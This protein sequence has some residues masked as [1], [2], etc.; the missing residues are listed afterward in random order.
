MIAMALCATQMTS[1]SS[2]SDDDGPVGGDT[3][4]FSYTYDEGLYVTTSGG[5]TAIS[6]VVV[7]YYKGDNVLV[8]DGF[9]FAPAMGAILGVMSISDVTATEDANGLITFTIANGAEIDTNYGTVDALYGE[10]IDGEINLSFNVVS[11]MSTLTDYPATF[12]GD[13]TFETGNFGP[14]FST[15]LYDEGLYVTTSSGPTAIDDVTVTYYEENDT[16]VVDGFTFSPMMGAIYG[17]M[18]I[19]GVVATEADNGLITLTISEDQTTDYGTVDE[20]FGEIIDGKINLSFNVIS[21]MSTLTDYPSTFYGDVT[22]DSGSYV[23]V[24]E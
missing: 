23:E 22:V 5:P 6:D 18:A 1:C 10:V 13:V 11:G 20:L 21:G 9:T 8:V 15:D 12:N 2:S 17:A 4:E 3:P 16:L 7:T 19:P 14:E 24:T